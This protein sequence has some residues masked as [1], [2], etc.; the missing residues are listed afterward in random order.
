MQV[1]LLLEHDFMG[2]EDAIREFMPMGFHETD[3]QGRPILIVNAG[4]FKLMELLQST[5][6]EN[7]TK[8]IIKEME[9][10]WRDKF[11]RCE[12]VY[13]PQKVDQIQLIIDLK[14]A[15]LKQIT[16]K[17]LNLLWAEISKELCKRF[18]EIVHKITIV[19]TPMFFESFFNSE[20]KPQLSAKTVAKISVTGE[21]TPACL[22][23]DIDADKLPAVYGGTCQCQA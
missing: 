22:L 11:E 15:T 9:H 16:N 18:P 2:K 13:K 4:Q 3:K 1:D 8:W 14:G 7:I 5:N 20:L 23:Q 19:N 6:P 12:Q 10:T 21:S 17:H